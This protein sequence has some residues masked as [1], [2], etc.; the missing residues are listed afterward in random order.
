MTIFTSLTGIIEEGDKAITTLL[1]AKIKAKR[2]NLRQTSILL[3]FLA[4]AQDLAK[5][6]SHYIKAI[7]PLTPEKEDS[8]KES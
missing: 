4:E 6:P 2:G 7:T 5:T 1:V 3:S 8:N